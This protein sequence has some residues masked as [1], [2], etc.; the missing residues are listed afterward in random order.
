MAEDNKDIK[1]VIQ[2]LWASV[3]GLASTTIGILKFTSIVHIP[4]LDAFIHIITGVMFIGGAWINR[5]QYVRRTNRWLG[6]FYVGF[7]ANGVNL[8][9]IIAGI[10]SL[11]IGLSA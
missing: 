7:G 6:I 3:I 9:H 8:P 4:T 10:V 5:G 1:M 11:V 2:R